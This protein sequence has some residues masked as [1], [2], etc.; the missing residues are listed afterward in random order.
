LLNVEW[1]ALPDAEIVSYSQAAPQMVKSS[2][3]AQPRIEDIV[4]KL[5]EPFSVTFLRLIDAS[6][7][8]DSEIYNRANID[9]SLLS[10]IRSNAH[11]APSKQTVIA[12]AIALELTLDQTEDLLEDSTN[13]LRY[14][15]VDTTQRRVRISMSH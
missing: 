7:K 4:G 6:G 15:A 1:D 9:H 14:S 10:K 13:R 11:Y 3:K 8:K 2:Y 12:F 5:D